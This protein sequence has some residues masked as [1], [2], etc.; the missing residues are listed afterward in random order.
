MAVPAWT[1]VMDCLAPWKWYTGNG[2]PEGRFE[3]GS[4]RSAHRQREPSRKDWKYSRFPLG[5]NSGTAS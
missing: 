3:R 1:L 5:E 4:R 2:A